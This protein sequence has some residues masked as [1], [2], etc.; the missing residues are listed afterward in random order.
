MRINTPKNCRKKL[1][2]I[3]LYLTQK[4]RLRPFIWHNIYSFLYFI[5]FDF[6]EKYECH[7]AGATY[8]KTDDPQVGF[9]N[10]V[11][12]LV[13]KKDEGVPE[14]L[15]IREKNVIKS[16]FKRLSKKNSNGLLELCQKDIPWRCA[17]E[18]ETIEY[19]S[20]FYRTPEYSVR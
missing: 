12:N 2:Q 15:T 5:D 3:V 11:D 8:I 4:S 19:E 17:Q 14:F 7:L 16:V 10:L 20:V 13:D 6:Y 9:L 18:D 1:R